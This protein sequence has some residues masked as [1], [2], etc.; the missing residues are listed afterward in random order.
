[1][2]EWINA[3]GLVCLIGYYV[4]ISVL[5]TMPDLP[6]SATYLERWAYAAAQAI[7]GNMKTLV[8]TMRPVPPSTEGKL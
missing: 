8:A 6:S 2:L 7:C 4:F 1:M 5:G 3:N